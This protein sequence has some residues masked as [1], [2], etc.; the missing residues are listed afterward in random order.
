LQRHPFAS[1]GK[2]EI[3]VPDHFKERM[4]RAKA[5]VGESDTQLKDCHKVSRDS[6][7]PGE[8]TP[9]NTACPG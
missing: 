2:P 4:S 3:S 1:G 6:Y 7:R 9:A 8:E 5:A